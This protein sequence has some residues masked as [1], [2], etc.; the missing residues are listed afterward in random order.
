MEYVV[1]VADTVCLLLPILN[2]RPLSRTVYVTLEAQAMWPLLYMLIKEFL[3]KQNRQSL[4]QFVSQ[5]ITYDKH[6]RSRL[7][8]L[9]LIYFISCY[10]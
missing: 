1:L 5:H 8:L 6:Q 7:I 10:R 4:V 9:K 3:D 2:L